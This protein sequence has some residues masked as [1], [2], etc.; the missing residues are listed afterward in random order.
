MATITY[1]VT[2]ASGTNQYGTGNKFYINGE[3]SPVL[4]LEEGNTYIFDQ[5]DSTNA[6]HIL[7]FSRNPNNDPTAAYTT[8]VT[9]TGTPGTDGKTTIVVAPVKKTGAPVLF[10]YCTVHSGMG[11][12]AQTISPTSGVSEFDPTIDDVIEEAFERTGFVGART[13]YHLRS[14]RRSLNILFQEWGNR[15][16]HLWK[17]KLATVP[18]VEGQAEYNFAS[19]SSNFPDDISDILEVY[20]R[21]N[22]TATAPV[23]TTMTKI[24]RSAY[25]ALPN[26]LSKGTPS[27][28]YVERKKNP[29]IF[30]YTTPSSSF[31]GSNYQL[32]F[33]YLAKIQD[34]GSY[35]YTADVVNR[36]LPCMMSGLAY[37]LGQKYS[38][39]RSQELERRYESELLRALDADNENTSTYISPQTF[40]GDGV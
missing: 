1:T 8:G 5:S 32:K 6:T 38:P 20:V 25:A 10:Y 7:A 2:V 21:N 17:V 28:Y 13:G 19:D 30:L 35:G 27:Q 23:D 39:E 33:Y 9:T 12:S 18:L 29:S 11:G 34:A 14:A 4:Y 26:K 24:D 3:V 36:F 40:Y 16:V 31:S 37:Y 15:G 22:T